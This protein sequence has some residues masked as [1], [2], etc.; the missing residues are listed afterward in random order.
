MRLAYLSEA[1]HQLSF[2]SHCQFKLRRSGL[3]GK[4]YASVALALGH[5]APGLLNILFRRCGH[6]QAFRFIDNAGP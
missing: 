1:E 5:L 4:L 3:H 6:P 2:D